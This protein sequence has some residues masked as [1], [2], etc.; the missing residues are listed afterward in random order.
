MLPI[1]ESAMGLKTS[2][3]TTVS[4]AT[5]SVNLSPGWMS[6]VMAVGLIKAQP[7]VPVS[8]KIAAIVV[9][10]RLLAAELVAP[11]VPPG[12]QLAAVSKSS[13]TL[14]VGAPRA[15]TAAVLGG[16]TPIG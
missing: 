15:A 1:V 2:S 6:A 13:T 9:L 16:T 5:P 10:T 7:V 12:V 14:R 11:A 4:A 3:T 8:Y